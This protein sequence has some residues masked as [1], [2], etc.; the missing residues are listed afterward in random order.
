MKK[1]CFSYNGLDYEINIDAIQ[2]ISK[3]HDSGGAV[4]KIAVKLTNGFEFYIVDK[5]E[6]RNF[7]DIWNIDKK[8]NH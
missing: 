2:Y 1:Y 6:I 4:S 5:T 8:N 3:G 7:L